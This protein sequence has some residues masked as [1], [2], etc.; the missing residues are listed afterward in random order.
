MQADDKLVPGSC[1]T[2]VQAVGCAL[3]LFDQDHLVRRTG[4]EAFRGEQIR[5]ENRL[6]RDACDEC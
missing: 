3:A 2:E 4:L 6:V 5:V 1:D